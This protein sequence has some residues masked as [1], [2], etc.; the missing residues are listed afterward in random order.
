MTEV[1]WSE[2]G[3]GAPKKKG[4]IPKW[5]WLG[6]GA[7][8]LVAILG[9]AAIS[10]GGFMMFKDVGNPEVQWPKLQEVLYFEERPTGMDIVG[11]N[12]LV[13]Y[14]YTL[15]SAQGHFQAKVRHFTKVGSSDFDDMFLEEPKN[16]PFG[17]SAPVEPEPGTVFVQG[18]S[19]RSLRFETLGGQGFVAELGPAIRVDISHSGEKVLV[20]YWRF[21]SGED[22]GTPITEEELK[23]FFD[24]FDV[25]RDD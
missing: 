10:V 21:S 20:E 3:E 7:G 15:T 5:V 22:Q 23:A 13:Y 4:G 19:V 16:A 6:C 25:W 9:I 17:L 12:A 1:E 14:E 11:V 8:C 18:E 2:E 24:H